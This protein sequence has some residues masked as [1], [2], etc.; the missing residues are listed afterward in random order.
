M[1]DNF[2][3]IK[4]V[5]TVGKDELTL[6]YIDG[7]VKDAAMEKLMLSFVATFNFGKSLVS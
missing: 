7:F 6:Y 1:D 2:D 4:K 5:L 3:I